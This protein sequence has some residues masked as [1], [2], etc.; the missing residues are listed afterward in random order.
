[1]RRLI[2]FTLMTLF[3]TLAMHAQTA[4]QATPAAPA[5]DPNKLAEEWNDRLNGLD[6]WHI[7]F[8]GEEDGLDAVVSHMMDMFA[9][10]VIAEVPPHDNEQIGPV[11]L[12]GRDQLR[13]WAEKIARSQVNISY[14]IRRQTEKEFEGE[15]MV[16]S[17]PLPWGGVGISFQVIGSYAMRED[18]TRFMAPGAVFLQYGSDGKIHRLRLLLAEIGEI[19]NI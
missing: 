4:P 19:T 10:D 8:A 11:M 2:V 9:P 3:T 16:Y 5:L 13:K 1:M 17:K 14:I 12:M 7:S 15:M 6:D 18:R